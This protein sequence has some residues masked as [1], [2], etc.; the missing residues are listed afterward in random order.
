MVCPQLPSWLPCASSLASSTGM[1]EFGRRVYLFRSQR[2]W[3]SSLEDTSQC[4]KSLGS[5]PSCAYR[6]KV[7]P[8]EP[9]L[10][11]S[12]I[13]VVPQV[14]LEKCKAPAKLLNPINH[15]RTVNGWVQKHRL[16]SSVKMPPPGPIMLPASRS[17]FGKR[18]CL[19][20]L[21]AGVS[22]RPHSPHREVSA[23][24]RSF[25]PHFAEGE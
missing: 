23:Y 17:A 15:G 21:I 3:V 18:F 1:S 14:R 7:P 12:L 16:G 20:L 4:K 2:K 13:L 22:E 11:N 10:G 6:G 8:E 19:L 9:A 24:F 5:E 25:P